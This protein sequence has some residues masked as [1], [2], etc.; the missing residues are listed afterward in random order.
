MLGFFG[1]SFQLAFVIDVINVLTLPTKLIYK[2]LRVIYRNCIKA[3]SKL[4]EFINTNEKNWITCPYPLEHINSNIRT[5]TF[6][7]LLI[8]FNLTIF[9]SFYYIWLAF[10]ILFLTLLQV[11]IVFN[12]RT[13]SKTFTFYLSNF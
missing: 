11:F 13:H 4:Y 7:L 10:I 9:T 3:I 2:F 1:L 6:G 8:L 12:Y 5:S